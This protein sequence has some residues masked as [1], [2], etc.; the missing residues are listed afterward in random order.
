[1]KKGID[2]LVKTTNSIYKLAILAAKRAQEL[3][4]GSNNLIEMGP[5]VKPATV[6]LQE[7]LE[8]KITYKVKEK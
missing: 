2:E 4:Q 8:N 3:S 1:M 7:I 6:A 5:N